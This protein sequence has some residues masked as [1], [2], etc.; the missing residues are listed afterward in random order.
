MKMMWIAV[1]MLAIT[2]GCSN[3][4]VRLVLPHG[5]VTVSMPSDYCLHGSYADYW[6]DYGST[7]G[8]RNP[9]VQIF[10][11]SE[12]V[13]SGPVRATEMIRGVLWY[14]IS[15]TVGKKPLPP[16]SYGL[17]LTFGDRKSA[18]IPFRILPAAL[19]TVPTDELLHAFTG[20]R[21]SWEQ[22]ESRSNWRSGTT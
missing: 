13:R 6:I 16:G 4:E 9:T 11:G 17:G 7:N 5:D 10:S 12:L 15:L 2:A 14:S 19:D 22:F 8:F 18:L 20:V 21:D 1:V 3:R